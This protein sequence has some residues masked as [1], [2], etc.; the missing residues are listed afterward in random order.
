M[1][2]AGKSL[3]NAISL[4]SALSDIPIAGVADKI[5]ANASEQRLIALYPAIWL[6]YICKSLESQ[7]VQLMTVL[8]GLKI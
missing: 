8:Y 2:C 1:M 7:L 5:M 4:A 3:P 6:W